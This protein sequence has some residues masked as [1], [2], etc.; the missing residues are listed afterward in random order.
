MGRERERDPEQY[1]NRQRV[2]INKDGYKVD[3]RLTK[4]ESILKIY[5]EVD[6]QVTRNLCSS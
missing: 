6:R 1:L 2:E 4:T 5:T 3:E